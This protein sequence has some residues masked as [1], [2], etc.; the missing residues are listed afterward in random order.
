MSDAVIQTGTRPDIPEYSTGPTEYVAG[1]ALVKDGI[2]TIAPSVGTAVVSGG[3]VTPINSEI[4]LRALFGAPPA[5]AN[6]P[7]VPWPVPA[8]APSTSL[9]PHVVAIPPQLDKDGLPWN[10]L[11]HSST[12]AL[13]NDGT[14]RVKRGVDKALVTKVTAELKQL[15]AIPQ[16]G[17]TKTLPLPLT[18]AQAVP[19]LPQIPNVPTFPVVPPVIAAP[20]AAPSAA[21]SVPPP[22]VPTIAAP[23]VVPVPPQITAQSPVVAPVLPTKPSTVGELIVAITAKIAAGTLNQ[24]MVNAA[25]TKFGIPAIPLL[26]ARPDLIPH[27]VAE[28]GL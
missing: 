10:Q 8:P 5:P 3:E 6:N 25:C 4:D 13:N 27:V 28:L 11:I 1:P 21:G 24:V 16:N 20:P 26:G 18:A 23:V 7:L 22:P 15:M 19:V 17:D 12:K 14:W 9:A 2:I